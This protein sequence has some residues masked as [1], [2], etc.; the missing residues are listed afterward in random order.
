MP[1]PQSQTPSSP[2]RRVIHHRLY[3]KFF[4][5]LHNLIVYH[6]SIS[7][8][9]YCLILYFIKLIIL[10]ILSWNLTF[11]I[12]FPQY[13][14]FEFHP[15]GCA[16]LRSMQ[17]SWCI[18]YFYFVMTSQRIYATIYQCFCEHLCSY[19][20]GSCARISKAVS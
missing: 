17:L 10:F 12:I 13:H 8:R 7:L 1:T 14:I 18:R 19:F 3:F 11:S 20:H 2:Q 4:A 5:F 15:C 6:L 9:I 16:Q